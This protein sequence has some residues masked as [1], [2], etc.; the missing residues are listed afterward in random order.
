MLRKIVG[1]PSLTLTK[2]QPDPNPAARQAPDLSLMKEYT[3]SFLAG[4]HMQFDRMNRR[5]FI[6]ALG[7]V[8]AWPLAARAQQPT[9]MPVVGFLNGQSAHGFTHLRD[10]FLQGLAEAGYIDGR[11]VAIEY[12]WADGD[13]NR[14]RA[15]AEELVRLR[16]TVIASGGGAQAA[17]K[18]A[19]ASIPIVTTLGGDPVRSGLVE[20]IKRPGGNLT[21]ASVFTVDIEAKRLEMMHELVPK[22]A[23]GVLMYRNYFLFDDQ[24]QEVQAAAQRLHQEL[25]VLDANTDGE[26]D[27]AFA[28]F[29]GVH[30]GG[31]VLV[32]NE[33]FNNRREH[34]VAVSARY[35][36]PSIH[37]NRE[38]TMAGGLM[39][40]GTNVPDV[41][42][43]VGIYTGRVLKGE[44]PA[45][46]PV[47]QPTKFDIAVNLKTA[48]ALGID[49]PTSILLRAN[50]VIE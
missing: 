44:S 21:G 42:R 46:L 11:N 7:G 6:T 4:L 24:L 28:E 23:I 8:A 29:A 36:L 3:A 22:A 17:A 27:K 12:R 41:Y 26:I 37:E 34:L 50:E 33:F 9:T 16:V 31:V 13:A 14:L 20:S 10:A 30:V 47:L 35:G 43:Q 38:F 39:S 25:R 5:T 49:V 48:K 1:G 19:T 45:E 40:Y 18:A 2:L 32:G 15:L